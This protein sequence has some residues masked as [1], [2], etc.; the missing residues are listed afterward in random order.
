MRKLTIFYLLVIYPLWTASAD[1]G[2]PSS[3]DHAI[4]TTLAH[5]LLKGALKA[6]FP[7]D[8]WTCPRVADLIRQKWGVTYHADHVLWLL[9]CPLLFFNQ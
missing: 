2:I 4:Q 9:Q 3:I 6:G 8:L 5:V 7:T 1:A